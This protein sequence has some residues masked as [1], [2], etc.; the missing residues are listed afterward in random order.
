MEAPVEHHRQKA[1]EDGEYEL[2]ED[3][4]LLEIHEDQEGLQH[5]KISMPVSFDEARL[6]RLLP[7]LDKGAQGLMGVQ[8]SISGKWPLEGI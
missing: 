1:E 2:E 3:A 5:Q 7:A 8:I 6:Q 4:Y